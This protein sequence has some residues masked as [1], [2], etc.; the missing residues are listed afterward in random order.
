MRILDIASVPFWEIAYVSA[1]VG[2]A[3]RATTLP[4]V[5]GTVDVPPSGVGALLVCS[6]LQ[7]RARAASGA[8]PASLLGEALATDLTLLA[9]SDEIPA[10]QHIGILLLGD[11]FADADAAIRGAHGEVGAVWRSFAAECRWV[12]GVAGNHDLIG[13]PPVLGQ[14]NAHLLDGRVVTVDGLRVGGISGVIGSAKAGRG[15]RR[16]ESSFVGAMRAVLRASPEILLLHQGPDGGT[17]EQPGH[18]AMREALERAGQV[19]T[20]CG[21]VHWPAPLA[22]LQGG[23]QVLNVDGRAVLLRARVDELGAGIGRSS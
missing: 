13:Q 6:D 2:G 11:L 15:W 10:T 7:G 12:V 1:E 5:L 8:S 16:D 14:E 21:H 23:S 20:L 22:T 9:E 3:S 18:P 19:L 17:P 4:L